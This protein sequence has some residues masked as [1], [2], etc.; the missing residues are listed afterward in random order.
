MLLVESPVGLLP[1][2][3][4]PAHPSFRRL[5]CQPIRLVTQQTLAEGQEFHLRGG[6]HVFSLGAP[7]INANRRFVGIG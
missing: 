2:D 5:R 4:N 6:M 1:V 3:A 7:A